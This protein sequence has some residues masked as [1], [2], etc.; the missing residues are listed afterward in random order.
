[1]AVMRRHS[2]YTRRLC[3]LYSASKAPA[4][5]CFARSIASASESLSPCFFFASVKS[6]F[7]AAL[8]QMRRKCLFVVLLAG[9][10]VSPSRVSPFKLRRNSAS[11]TS[12]SPKACPDSHLRYDA[13]HTTLSLSFVVPSPH[14]APV[15]IDSG[16]AG[17][18][19]RTA[20]KPGRRKTA[21]NVSNWGGHEFTRAAKC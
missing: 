6:C 17:K 7:P 4:S 2:E 10:L 13:V 3:R 9:T 8:N 1:L 11:A 18:T 21:P 16:P 5:P 14:P 15:S 19:Q 20:V 12:C